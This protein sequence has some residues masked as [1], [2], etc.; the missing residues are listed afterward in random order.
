MNDRTILHCLLA[1]SVTDV[2][3]PLGREW[4]LLSIRNLCESSEEV[5]QYIHSLKPQEVVVEDD[6]LTKIKADIS[7]D[8]STGKLVFRQKN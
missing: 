4:A 1:Y 8:P 2:D 7:L 6:F 3:L 5:R